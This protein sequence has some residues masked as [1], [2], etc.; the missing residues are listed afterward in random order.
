MEKTINKV[1]FYYELSNIKENIINNFFS[2]FERNFINVS[3]FFD[4]NYIEKIPI[5]IVTKTELDIF[6]KNTSSQYRNCDI[7]KW[8][9]GFSTPKNIY[10]LLP[11][12]DN[13]EEMVKVALHETVHFIIYQMNLKQPPLKVLDEGL[14]IYLSQQNSKKAFNLIVNEYLS[15]KLRNLS[16]FC[17]YNSVEFAQLR[18]YQYSYYIAEFLILTYGKSIYISW[19][20]NPDNFLNELPIFNVAFKKYLTEKI[21]IAVEKKLGKNNN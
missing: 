10:I 11:H 20:K 3:N 8:L 4:L 18:G 16:D 1:I 14:A 13:V 7:P 6:V 12:L 9:D 2:I 21:I 5:H 17:I 15:N 19:L